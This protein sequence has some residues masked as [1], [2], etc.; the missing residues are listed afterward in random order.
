MF[1]HDESEIDRKRKLHLSAAEFIDAWR[2]FPRVL[3]GLYAWMLYK[4]FNWYLSL[5]PYLLEGCDLE[6]LGELCVVAAPTTGQSLLL[7][8]VFGAGTGIFGL[9]A[10]TGRKWDQGVKNWRTPCPKKQSQSGS[11]TPTE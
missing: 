6:K 8:A 10:S 11:P 1:D 3:A 9:Y 4:M 2:L 7:S 5:E